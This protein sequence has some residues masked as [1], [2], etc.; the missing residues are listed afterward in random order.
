[1]ANKNVNK[2]STTIIVIASIFFIVGTF[3]NHQI[4]TLLYFI[5]FLLVCISVVIPYVFVRCPY[6]GASLA[7]TWSDPKYCPFCGKD[8]KE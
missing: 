8:L 1:M 7:R 3:F 5:G 4:A 6:C 2:I